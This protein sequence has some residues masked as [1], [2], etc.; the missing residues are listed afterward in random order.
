VVEAASPIPQ[1]PDAALAQGVFCPALGVPP[2]KKKPR[3]RTVC[4]YPVARLLFW[5]GRGAV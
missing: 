5:N 3:H 4:F 1:C 2:D